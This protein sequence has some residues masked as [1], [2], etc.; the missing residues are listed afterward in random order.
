MKIEMNKQV[1]KTNWL[2]RMGWL[3]FIFFLIKGLFWLAL[4]FGL[5]RTID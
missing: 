5:F 2:R 4:V 3:A 1:K